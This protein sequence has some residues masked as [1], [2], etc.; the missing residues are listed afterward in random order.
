MSEP[1]TNTDHSRIKPSRRADV[2]PPAWFEAQRRKPHFA[3]VR[4]VFLSWR[5]APSA[6]REID[7]TISEGD[8]TDRADLDLPL[9]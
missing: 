5:P 6:V 3:W 1:Y 8:P 7:Y 9:D 4:R 2:W